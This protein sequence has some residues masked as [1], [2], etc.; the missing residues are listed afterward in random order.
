MDLFRF[1]L[2]NI[3]LSLYLRRTLTAKTEIM[4]IPNTAI[5]NLSHLPNYKSNTFKINKVIQIFQ[6]NY[7]VH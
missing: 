1:T 5:L 2:L 7:S 6:N 4:T 3:F